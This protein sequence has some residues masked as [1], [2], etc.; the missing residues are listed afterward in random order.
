M[1]EIEEIN[2]NI[3][4]EHEQEQE[5]KEMEAVKNIKIN[6][7]EFFKF[8]NKTKRGKSKIG[9]LRSGKDYLS[10]PADMAR[11]LSEQY[12][13]VFSSPKDNYEELQFPM[14]A[15]S[16]MEDIVLTKEMFVVAMSSMKTS[17]APGPD[18][19]PAYL[20]QR[21]A[22]VLVEPIMWIWKQSLESGRMPEETLLAY[23][24]P[25]LKSVDR[26]LPANYRPVSLT[27]HL[28]KIFERVLRKEMVK[29]L[30][31]QE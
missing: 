15:I 18:G 9:P 20:Y 30:E 29:H 2:T 14:R 22:E 1:K 26:S 24:N 12:K 17:S 8:A 27:N 4:Q 25:I 16:P 19:V 5:R 23:I 6:S 13:S 3:Q 21:F 7:T 10:G 31:S 11:I 28:T